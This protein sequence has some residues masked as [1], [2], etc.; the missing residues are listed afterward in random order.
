MPVRWPCQKLTCWRRCIR[1]QVCV[2]ETT[3]ESLTPM[4]TTETSTP[5]LEAVV[6]VAEPLDHTSESKIT[7]ADTASLIDP[8]V[9]ALAPVAPIDTAVDGSV[10]LLS[11][12]IAFS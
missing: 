12:F 3:V 10:N 6:S 2:S 1:Q 8:G 7:V 4:D 9:E 5:E 11:A